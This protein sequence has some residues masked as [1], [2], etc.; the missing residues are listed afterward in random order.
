MTLSTPAEVAAWERAYDAVIAAGM[1]ES[2]GTFADRKIVELRKRQ[3]PTATHDAFPSVPSPPVARERLG[4]KKLTDW[5]EM[6]VTGVYMSM[7]RD[8]PHDVRMR[9][10]DDGSWFVIDGD[11]RVI[12]SGIAT[13]GTFPTLLAAAQHAADSSAEARERYEWDGQTPDNPTDCKRCGASLAYDGALFCG[14][15]CSA[16]WEDGDRSTASMHTSTPPDHLANAGKKV[17]PTRVEVE[18]AIEAWDDT[19]IKLSCWIGLGWSESEFFEYRNYGTI[20]ARPLKVHA[21]TID[22]VP[23]P[24]TDTLSPVNG[25]RAPDA[26]RAAGREMAG[27][28]LVDAWDRLS[29]DLQSIEAHNEMEAAVSTAVAALIATK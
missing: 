12:A 9:A 25:T 24:V 5:I 22:A 8:D 20:P 19:K 3:T 16:M 29:N 1:Q 4:R 7:V 23:T 27:N 18:A 11:D 10:N 28:R 13:L 17:A 21:P 14:A 26:V 2:A 15:A 6:S